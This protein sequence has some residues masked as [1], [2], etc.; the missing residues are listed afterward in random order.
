MTNLEN[1]SNQNSFEEMKFLHYALAFKVH[2]Y[3]KDWEE[4]G[5][6]N[7]DNSHL[8]LCLLQKIQNNESVMNKRAFYKEFQ[9]KA[10]SLIVRDANIIDNYKYLPEITKEYIDEL[11]KI[12]QIFVLNP[13]DSNLRLIASW[14]RGEDLVY[15]RLSF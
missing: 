7:G 12:D 3:I 15:A 9:I 4:S 2:E 10:K 5:R 6:C 1:L 8:L 13:T 14:W 11:M